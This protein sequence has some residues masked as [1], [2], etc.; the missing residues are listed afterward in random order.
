MILTRCLK[1]SYD[2]FNL[3]CDAAERRCELGFKHL[4][5]MNAKHTNLFDARNMSCLAFR[6]LSVTCFI[7]PFITCDVST[8][9]FMTWET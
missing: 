2:K 4:Q 9:V 1:P 7:K 8:K 3:V 5:R 6:F